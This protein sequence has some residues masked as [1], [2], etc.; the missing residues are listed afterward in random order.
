[1]VIRSDLSVHFIERTPKTH[2]GNNISYKYLKLKKSG[3]YCNEIDLLF[4]VIT[5][6]V[7]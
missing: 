6:T 2:Q 4:Q 1:M 7:K 3:F 5:Q